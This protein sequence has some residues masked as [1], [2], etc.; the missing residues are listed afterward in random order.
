MKDIGKA[1]DS[2]MKKENKRVITFDLV[3]DVLE[4]CPAFAFVT[5]KGRCNWKA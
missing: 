4:R 5:G 3:I 2:M 1:L